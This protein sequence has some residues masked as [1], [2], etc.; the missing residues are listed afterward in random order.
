MSSSNLS[1]FCAVDKRNMTDFILLSFGNRMSLRST[2]DTNIQSAQNGMETGNLLPS[3]VQP[4]QH[5]AMLLL[6]PRGQQCRTW[7]RIR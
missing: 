6:V 5:W 4:S 3:A 7:R 1:A 2:T